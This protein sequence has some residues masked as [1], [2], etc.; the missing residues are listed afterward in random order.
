MSHLN[1]TEAVAIRENLGSLPGSVKLVLLKDAGACDACKSLEEECRDIEMVS[2]RFRVEI[3][4]RLSSDP[5]VLKYDVQR[6]PALV[7]EGVAGGR[8]RFFG[9]PSG[10]EFA[11]FLKSLG[12]AARGEMDLYPNTRHSFANLDT[13]IHLE[14]VIPP[15][16]LFSPKAAGAAQKLAFTFPQVRADIIKMADFPDLMNAYSSDYL[17]HVRVN[18][19]HLF[20]K[21]TTEAEMADHI[22]ELVTEQKREESKRKGGGY[23]DL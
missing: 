18:G 6:A 5:R 2:S 11:D 16:V 8:V 7:V 10:I 22:L 23:A 9:V 15:T 20:P 12:E 1:L 4:D 17:T 14:V 3:L 13:P 21:G 19:R